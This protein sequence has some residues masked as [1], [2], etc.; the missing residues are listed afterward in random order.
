MTK[1]PVLLLIETS[2]DTCSVAICKGDR[3][4]D[5][6][7]SSEPRAQAA[8]IGKMIQDILINNGTTVND[9]DAV[10]VS[11]GPGSYTGLRVGVS[12]AKG[13]CYGA[14][15][16]LI[17]V[18][19]L[20]LIAQLASK[21]NE[22]ALAV[23]H[24]IIPMIDARRMEVY[25]FRASSDLSTISETTAEV[26][27]SESFSNELSLGSVL[28]AGEG[29]M[30]IKDVITHPNA[31]YSP[32]KALASGM[33]LPALAKYLKGEFVDTAYFEPF[34]LK[35]FVAGTSKKKFF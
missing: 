8:K 10:V 7:V 16:P 6:L 33:I 2:T 9:C 20:L 24:T 25:C 1:E 34:Y 5:E 30:K 15:K 18:S 14:N 23:P 4:I 13:L 28:F 29:A 31:H 35:D 21:T 26:V 11:E 27:D 19:S 22:C 17:A 3:L 12:A 32:V